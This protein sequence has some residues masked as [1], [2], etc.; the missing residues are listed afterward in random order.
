VNETDIAAL[1]PHFSEEQSV[2]LGML[3]GLVNL[4]N[5]LSDP[6]SADLEFSEEKI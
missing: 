1:K 3:V 5:R 6:L 4:T 2:D